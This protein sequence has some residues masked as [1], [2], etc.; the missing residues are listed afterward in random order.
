M[1]TIM[2]VTTILVAVVASG[3]FMSMT[4]S[5]QLNDPVAEIFEFFSTVRDAQLSVADRLEK[6]QN[7]PLD[8][9]HRCSG[10][11]YNHQKPDMMKIYDEVFPDNYHQNRQ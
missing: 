10:H 1:L 5:H 4:K 11:C 6:F 7:I 9:V 2:M 8:L 3:Q